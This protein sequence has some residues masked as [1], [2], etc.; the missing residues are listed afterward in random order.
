MEVVDETGDPGATPAPDTL[1][2]PPGSG[3]PNDDQGQGDSGAD[4]AAAAA[5]TVKL[6]SSIKP[7]KPAAP[8]NPSRFQG[9]ISELVAQRKAEQARAESAEA[10]LSRLTSTTSGKGDT[11]GKGVT[12]KTGA[13]ALNPD[14]FDTYPE[15]IA[16]F[17]KEII[18][19]QQAATRSQAAAESHATHMNERHESFKEESAPFVEAYG[20][21]FWADIT[22][23]T[24]PISEVMSDAVL[25]LDGGLGP[26]TMLYLAS[27][28]VEA[29]NINKM[30]PMRAVVEIGK[31]AS[32]LDYE[33]KHGELAPQNTGIDGETQQISAVPTVPEVPRRPVPTAVPVL[34]GQTPADLGGDPSDK[35]DIK[36]WVQK[37]ASRMR[38]ANPHARFYS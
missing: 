31:I 36:T 6:P 20:D 33:M 26:L 9:R 27:H 37:E 32:R 24:L 35:E 22:D 16:A 10:A 23:P 29:A 14:D 1:E 13:A 34:R 11:P 25:E 30:N 3:M 17:T 18:S 2:P 28:R 5:K 4:P 7:P 15:Y 21:S 19:E 12:P 38:R 8:G